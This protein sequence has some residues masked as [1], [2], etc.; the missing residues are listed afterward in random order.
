MAWEHRVYRV[1]KPFRTLMIILAVLLIAA[2]ILAV[3][4]FLGFRNYIVYTDDGVRL[5]IPWLTEE[6]PQAPEEAQIAQ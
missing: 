3:A 4:I 6:E 1:R 2:V 5:E